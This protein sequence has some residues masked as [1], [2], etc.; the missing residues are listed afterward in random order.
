[1]PHTCMD[2]AD[3]HTGPL[4]R[5]KAEASY[6]AHEILILLELL[7]LRDSWWSKRKHSVVPWLMGHFSGAGGSLWSRGLL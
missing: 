3:A 7:E 5:P 1:M 6:P 2:T 4:H